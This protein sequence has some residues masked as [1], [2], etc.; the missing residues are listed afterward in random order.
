MKGAAQ[1]DRPFFLER[2]LLFV[3]ALLYGIRLLG[4]ARVIWP[5][6]GACAGSAGVS[7][8]RGP[9]STSGTLVHGAGAILH[10]AL[11]RT[12]SDVALARRTATGLGGLSKGGR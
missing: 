4:S 10:R 12:L 11:R 3:D 1:L 8:G 9:A 5:G 6:C 2:L 7:A